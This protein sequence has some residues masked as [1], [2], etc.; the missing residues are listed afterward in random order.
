MPLSISRIKREGPDAMIVASR[1]PLAEAVF[2]AVL[3]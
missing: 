3:L 2:A 1:G